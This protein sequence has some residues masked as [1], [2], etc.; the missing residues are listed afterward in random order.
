[1]P[2]QIVSGISGGIGSRYIRSRNQLVF[3]EYTGGKISVVDLIRPLVTTVAQGTTVI[4]GTW[5]FDCETGALGGSLSGP[6]DI[7]WDQ[8][9][10]VER[11]MVPVGGAKIVNLGKINF[12]QVTHATLQSLTYGTTPIPGNDDATNQLGDGD[13]FAVHTNAGNYAKVQ[14]L[15]YGYN[16]TV[17]WV[18]YSVGPRYRVLG[19]GY[20]EPEDI[21][22]SAN[23]VTAYVT[24]RSGN[25]LRVS[26]S[27]ANRASAFV[28]ASGLTAPHQIWLDEANGHAYVVEFAPVGRLLRIPLAGGAPTVLASNLENAIGLL[29]TSDRSTAYVSEQASS[30]GRV[31]RITLNT[32]ARQVVATGLTRPFFMTWADGGESRILV[33]DREPVNRVMMVDI[34]QT[35]ATVTPAATGLPLRPSSC[36]VVEAGRLLVCCES[37]I[38][39]VEL[40]ALTV[41][42]DGPLLMGIGHVPFDRISSTTGLAD[43]SVDPTYPYQFRNVP[44]GGTLPL[45]VNH[46]RAYALGARYYRVMV[47]GAPRFDA[48]TDYRWNAA[49]NRYEARTTSPVS[50]ASGSGY[51]PVHSPVE[52]F[53]WLHPAL[54]SRMN[55]VGLADALHTLRIDFVND[56]G[57]A[58]ASSD[59]IR[60][61]INNKPCTATIA[62]PTLNGSP[63]DPVCGTLKY[64][65]GPSGTVSMAF[66]ASHPNGFATYSFSL[67]KG[68]ST[69]TPPST[70]GP[71]S[72]A[73]AAITATA[74]DLLGKCGVAGF[75][76]RIY[77]ATTIINGEVRQ[78]QY[79]A[80][81]AIAFVLAPA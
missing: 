14:V 3:V 47:D 42:P 69:L 22:V 2:T 19:T 81:A 20:S 12:D 10:A 32:A 59:T 25:L 63:A 13:V 24:E 77:V 4:N 68:V 8:R 48:W 44:F 53:L 46:Q 43:T 17:R 16:L 5:V 54:G 15:A 67:V 78:S 6:G 40:P 38:Q 11:R 75:A 62:V 61:L 1:M 7:W 71:V 21:A 57:A 36:A 56:A 37:E 41:V 64:P 55:S 28:V 74:A 76:E 65:A 66:T 31:V 79:D 70:S 23:D 33:T 51:Y 29:I 72:A 30:G 50:L 26:L 18:T 58:V 9:T 60:V 35:P 34:T 27:S 45:L 80:S 52:L 39:L 73:P 49:L